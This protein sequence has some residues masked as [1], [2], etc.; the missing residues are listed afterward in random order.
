M[1][2]IA[3]NANRLFSEMFWR[4]KVSGVPVET[5]NG[6]ALRIP[7]PVLTT[8]RNPTERVLFHP[9]RD[10]NP[11]FHLMESIWMLAGRRDVAFPTQ[12]NSTFGQY[13][14]DGEVYNAAYGYRWRSHFGIDQLAE[15]I[16]TLR[17]DRNTRQAVVQMWDA[18]DL[19]KATKD[20][21]CNMS[22]VFEVFNDRLNMTV[23]NRSNDAW[24]GYAGAN[25]VHMTFLQEFIAHA[26]GVP[27]GV[28]RTFSTNLH[29]YTKLYEASQY[30][31]MPP[32]PNMYDHYASGVCPL[33]IM[34]NG[35]WRAFLS[36]CEAFCD[37]PFNGETNYTHPF[38]LGVAHPM[39]MVSR[40]RKL[41]AGTGEGC[42]AKIKAPD[43]RR[44][45]FEWVQRRESKKAKAIA[46]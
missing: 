11:V 32:D 38:F 17:T 9:G 21:A 19:S 40:T 45:V 33:P 42:A 8:V 28:Y 12:F 34:L 24:F 29:L 44:A 7:E 4:F 15:V 23:I 2:I 13:S 20:K 3:H 1:D 10:A 43:W 14:D 26:V 18:A 31:V 25:I 6:P 41:N 5:R 30:L 37:D 35:D 36:D 16:N 46:V 22:I 39:A 27:I